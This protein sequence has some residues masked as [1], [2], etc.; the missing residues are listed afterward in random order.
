[1]GVTQRCIANQ[2]A[3]GDHDEPG[4][5]VSEL[6]S[7]MG[8]AALRGKAAGSSGCL[9]ILLLPHMPSREHR[10]QESGSGA[11][12][13][14]IDPDALYVPK[15]VAEMLAARRPTYTTSS[16]GVIWPV[17]RSGLDRRAS[18]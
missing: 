10:Y 6:P 13:M 15:E 14:K 2:A 1:M 7:R 8:D 4:Q 18:E 16:R 11:R 3:I 9:G 12:P 17:S 5:V